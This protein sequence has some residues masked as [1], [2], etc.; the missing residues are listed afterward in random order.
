[1]LKAGYGFHSDLSISNLTFQVKAILQKN[2]LENKA[3][4]KE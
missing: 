4:I 2:K 1:V 3:V